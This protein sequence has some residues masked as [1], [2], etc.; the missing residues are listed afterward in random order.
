MADIEYG[1]VEQL[2]EKQDQVAT[3]KD[4]P[5]EV[6]FEDIVT[7]EDE[8]TQLKTDQ[9]QEEK[10]LNEDNSDGQHERTFVLC[11][12]SEEDEL[13]LGIDTPE[14]QEEDMLLFGDNLLKPL[15][16]KEE[17]GKTKIKWTSTIQKLKAFVQLVVKCD[18]TWSTSPCEGNAKKSYTFEEVGSNFS[19]IWWPTNGTVFVQGKKEASDIIDGILNSVIY[20]M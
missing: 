14:V 10:M 13:S 1:Q 8:T 3:D 2:H 17:K 20:K 9:E 11:S 15:K 7:V 6:L 19:L 16:R 5:F 12:E 4:N 18:G